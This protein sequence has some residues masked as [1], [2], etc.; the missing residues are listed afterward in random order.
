M[1]FCLKLRIPQDQSAFGT[2]WMQV[3]NHF[4]N[5]KAHPPILLTNPIKSCCSLSYFKCNQVESQKQLWINNTEGSVFC[6]GQLESKASLNLLYSR[7]FHM[8]TRSSCAVHGCHTTEQGS[9]CNTL[10]T[11]SGPMSESRK[12]ITV[13]MGP[14]TAAIQTQVGQ[15]SMFLPQSSCVKHQP[16]GKRASATSAPQPAASARSGATSRRGGCPGRWEPPPGLCLLS[17]R[18]SLCVWGKGEPKQSIVKSSWKPTKGSKQGWR[19]LC[20]YNCSCVCRSSLAGLCC[21]A[22]RCKIERTRSKPPLRSSTVPCHHRLQVSHPALPRRDQ[23]FKCQR[24]IL[25]CPKICWSSQQLFH[26]RLAQAE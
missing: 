14:V 1:E 15:N 11:L 24:F 18:A 22:C 3:S 9:D 5:P 12:W 16:P 10:D 7:L 23:E 26:H 21:A 2:S 17:W 20:R 13:T 8:G 25:L 4:R 6:N 19:V